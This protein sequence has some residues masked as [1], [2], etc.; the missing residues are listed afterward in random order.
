[1]TE[2]IKYHD[3]PWLSQYEKGVRA[4]MEYE[5]ICLPEILERTTAMFPNNMALLFQGYKVSY[6]E[7]N[8][9]VNRF[10]ACL[11]EFGIRKGDS[12]S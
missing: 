5:E 1:M 8:A 9:M 10:A 4:S 3:K 2:E 7:L 6:R 12:V 11:H